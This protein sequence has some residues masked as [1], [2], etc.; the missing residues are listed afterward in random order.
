MINLTKR[1]IDALEKST[2]AVQRDTAAKQAATKALRDLTQDDEDAQPTPPPVPKG[3]EPAT[4][5]STSR[6]A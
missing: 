5:Q 4:K 3:K 6:K 2:K 1:S